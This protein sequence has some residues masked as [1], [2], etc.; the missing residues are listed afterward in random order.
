VEA[1]KSK[2]TAVRKEQSSPTCCNWKLAEGKNLTP[3]PTNYAGCSQAKEELLS[4][5]PQKVP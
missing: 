5:N 2:K 4:N 3:H 1:A